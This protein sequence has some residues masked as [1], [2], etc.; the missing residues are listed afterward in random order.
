M[1]RVLNNSLL[2]DNGPK[3]LVASAEATMAP[4]SCYDMATVLSSYAKKSMS[5][6]MHSY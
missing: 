3:I 6:G 4:K 2:A 5:M 1:F